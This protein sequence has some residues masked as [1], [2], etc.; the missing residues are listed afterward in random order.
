MPARGLQRGQPIALRP[1]RAA[2]LAMQARGRRQVLDHLAL[3]VAT[4]LP[5]DVIGFLKRQRDEALVMTGQYFRAAARPR[6]SE[7]IE[8]EALIRRVIVLVERQLQSQ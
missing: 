7:K 4:L 6:R 1:D 2:G 3:R 5:L 8:R